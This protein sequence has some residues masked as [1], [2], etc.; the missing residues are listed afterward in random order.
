MKKKLIVGTLFILTGIF[1]ISCKHKTVLDGLP[2]ISFSADIAPIIGS[3]CTM[4]GCHGSGKHKSMNTYSGVMRRVNP[5]DP[6]GSS[7]YQRIITQNTG[8]VMPKPPRN[9]LTEDNIKK[10]YLWIAQGAANN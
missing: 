1:I 5:G 4:S 10:I 2:Q 8:S 9:P 6:L 3:N 7:L